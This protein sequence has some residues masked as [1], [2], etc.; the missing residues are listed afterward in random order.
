MTQNKAIYTGKTPLSTWPVNISFFPRSCHSWAMTD[1]FTKSY[2][3]TGNTK[4]MLL[5]FQGRRCCVAGPSLLQ[6]LPWARGSNAWVCSKFGSCHNSMQ[7]CSEHLP[8]SSNHMNWLRKL[9]F[10]SNLRFLSHLQ[11][12]G[13][14]CPSQ[15][16]TDPEAEAALPVE[17]FFS[18]QTLLKQVS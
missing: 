4:A 3:L 11:I 8:F 14:S 15:A 13:H 6:L 16:G 5:P 10:L 7:S 1:L 18:F 17:G 9:V 2:F 12:V